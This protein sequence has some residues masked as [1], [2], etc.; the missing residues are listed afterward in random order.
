MGYIILEIIF[1]VAVGLALY[2]VGVYNGLILLS[3]NID[4]AW[5]NIDVLLKPN[6]HS[7]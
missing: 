5:A 7:A 4:K 3:R 6:S 2:F 1:F